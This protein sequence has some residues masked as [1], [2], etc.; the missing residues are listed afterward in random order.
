ME[1]LKE[2]QEFIQRIMLL[3][4]SR[5]MCK[6]QKEFAA[7]LGV[8]KTGLSSAMNGNPRSL[9]DSLVMKVQ[10]FAIVN[11]LDSEPQAAKTETIEVPAGFRETLENLSSVLASQARL[12][13]SQ[14][15]MLELYQQHTGTALPGSPKNFIPDVR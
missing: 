6:T 5:G 13:E 2:K 11:G 10:A 14:A 1:T 7:L 8:D 4:K 3:A 12:L 9:T 15:R